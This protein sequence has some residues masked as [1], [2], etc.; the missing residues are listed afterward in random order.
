MKPTGEIENNPTDE[1]PNSYI[2]L[3]ASYFK[4]G[5]FFKWASHCVRDI[6]FP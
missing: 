6:K 5:L 1:H 2:D 4:I 3:T